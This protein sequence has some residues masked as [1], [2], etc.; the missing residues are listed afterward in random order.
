MQWALIHRR[1]IAGVE[2]RCITEIVSDGLYQTFG[3]ELRAQYQRVPPEAFP[4]AV[5]VDDRWVSPATLD[6]NPEPA[7]IPSFGRLSALP[8]HL[9][10]ADFKL[11][12]SA[13][14]R[15]A[16]KA[17][18]DP[19]VVDFLD[20]V[21]DPRC[22]EIDLAHP[23]IQAAIAYLEAIGMLARGRAAEIL[24]ARPAMIMPEGPSRT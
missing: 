10:V 11:C 2:R 13:A 15:I 4:A 18:A 17:S 6:P 23:Q 9:P 16:I 8:A 1:V 5:W 14:E 7:S 22:V 12:F 21:D 3:P 20:I 19:I 24:A